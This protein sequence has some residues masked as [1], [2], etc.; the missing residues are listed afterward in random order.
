MKIYFS[1]TRF[2]LIASFPYKL[3]FQCPR[4]FSGEPFNL[5]VAHKIVI[6]KYLSVNIRI[7][8]PPY[9]NRFFSQSLSVSQTNSGTC[10]NFLYQI[11]NHY[12][13]ISCLKISSNKNYKLLNLSPY[14]IVQVR[15]KKKM[16]VRINHTIFS[17][18]LNC[19][20]MISLKFIFSINTLST[21]VQPMINGAKKSAPLPHINKFLR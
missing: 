21:L 1:F 6:T 15:D 8:I 4:G 10:Y 2:C 11:F 3:L 7:P 19:F 12:G 13:T 20:Q 17:F 5:P 14:D 18:V 9:F 16:V